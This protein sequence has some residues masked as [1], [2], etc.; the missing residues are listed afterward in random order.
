M[1]FFPTP[2]ALTNNE[3]G[4]TPSDDDFFQNRL[5]KGSANLFFKS[6]TISVESG[7]K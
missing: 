3:F 6:D 2:T 4:A 1:Q 7:F 5:D